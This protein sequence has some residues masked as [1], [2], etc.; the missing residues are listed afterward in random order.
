MSSAPDSREPPALP[1]SPRAGTRGS[2]GRGLD[3]L[4]PAAAES[5]GAALEVALNAIDPNPDQPRREFDQQGLESLAAS[6]RE[7]GIVQPLVVQPLS[8]GR[9]QLIAGERRWRAAQL[10]ELNTVPVIVSEAPTE[11]RLTLALVENLQREDL[12]PIEAARAF[13]ELASQGWSHRR[14]AERIGKSRSAVANQIRLLQLPEALQEQVV[15]GRLSEGHARALLLAP[16]PK[17]EQLAR[18]AINEGLSVRAL[19]ERARG[20]DG[21]PSAA[22]PPLPKPL[23]EDFAPLATQLSEAL[24]TRVLVRRGARGGRVIIHW[25]DVEQVEELL[26]RLRR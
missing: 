26:K 21:E 7:H 8:A 9:Y 20:E 13:A 25:D 11:D 4:L 16:K 22:R 19:E 6:I 2:L 1:Q 14:I 24:H 12:N 18:T 15:A 17:R 10:A 23:S 3:A 5:S